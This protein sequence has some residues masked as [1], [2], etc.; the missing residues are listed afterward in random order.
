MKSFIKKSNLVIRAV[1]SMSVIAILG[2]EA[3]DPE[4]GVNVSA[5]DLPE[6]YYITFYCED[7]GIY[8]NTC[9]LDNPDNP[10]AN[11]TY[12]EFDDPDD[13]VELVTKWDMHDAAPSA[14][15]RFYLWST[16]LTRIPAG[17]NQ[18]YAARALH[19][20]YTVDQNEITKEQVIKA[21]RSVLDNFFGHVTYFEAT[22]SG[23]GVYYANSLANL[24]GAVMRNPT[25]EGLSTLYGD[26]YKLLD[27]LTQ[28]GYLYDL[29][30]GTMTAID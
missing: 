1:A 3:P 27:A 21:Y 2:C 7:E 11:A 26:D 22:W 28:W 6:D 23:D 10:Y 20:I 5:V 14:K 8:P 12:A 19:E 29:E 16:Q 24:V 25:A 13:D 9:V 30:S 18:Y 4:E 17:E 15:A